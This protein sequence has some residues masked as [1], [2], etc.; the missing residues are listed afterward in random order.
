MFACCLGHA[1]SGRDVDADKRWQLMSQLHSVTVRLDQAARD[2]EGSKEEHSASNAGTGAKT[3]REAGEP[4]GNGTAGS[5]S[6]SGS[7]RPGSGKKA[8][9]KQA[10]QGKG[11]GATVRAAG[12]GL[13]G[14]PWADPAS[15]VIPEDRWER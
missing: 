13:L 2:A 5:G 14:S 4:A 6:G 1:C 9:G 15:E 11:D 12:G 8:R 10:Q 7:G 3:S